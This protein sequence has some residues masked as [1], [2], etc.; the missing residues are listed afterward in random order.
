MH[1]AWFSPPVKNRNGKTFDG[2]A[3]VSPE[4]FPDGGLWPLPVCASS[5]PTADT[6]PPLVLIM[7]ANQSERCIDKE[8]DD[9]ISIQA[10]VP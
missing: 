4:S 1:R 3:V 9:A 2:G 8:P 10:W 7:T 6:E 5:V